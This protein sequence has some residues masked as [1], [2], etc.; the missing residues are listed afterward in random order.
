MKKLKTWFYRFSD[1]PTAMRRVSNAM[2]ILMIVGFLFAVLGTSTTAAFADGGPVSEGGVSTILSM[3]RKIGDLFI[4]IAYSLMVILFAVGTVKSG[5]AAQAAQQFGAAGRVSLEFMN[6]ATGVV[7]FVVGLISMPLVKWILGEI[8]TM[9][10][11]ADMKITIPA[12]FPGG[13]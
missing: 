12:G 10:N 11:P 4:S 8:S 5:L 2:C 3:F 13:G 6:L 7:I 9:I 1:S